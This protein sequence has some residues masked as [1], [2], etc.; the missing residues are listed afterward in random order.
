MKSGFD[1]WQKHLFELLTCLFVVMIGF[2]I[3]LPVLPFYL[4]RLALAAGVAPQSVVLHVTPR[5]RGPKISTRCRRHKPESTA[6]G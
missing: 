1:E 6:V 4:E 2:G 3:T 5:R